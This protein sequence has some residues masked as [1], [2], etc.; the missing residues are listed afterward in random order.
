MSLTQSLR[1]IWRHP[2]NRGRRLAAVGRFVNWQTAGRI[3]KLP[4]LV[5]L[6]DK[7][8]L[9]ARHGTAAGATGN[10]YCGLH[11]FPDMPFVAHLLREGDLFLD[12][13]ANIGSYTVLAGTRGAQVIAAEPVPGT[14][15]SLRRNVGL[16]LLGDA[17]DAQQVALGESSGS[18]EMTKDFDSENHIAPGNADG[19]TRSANTVTV[20]MR[21]LDD[22][23]GDRSPRLMKLDVEGFEK[24][25]LLGAGRVLS[26]PRLLAIVIELN[27][28]GRRYGVD[29]G[30]IDA[31]LR[32][33][34]FAPHDYDVAA[35]K[36][37]PLDHF[38][39]GGNTIYARS[40]DELHP[41]LQQ[42]APV[43]IF[44]RDV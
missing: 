35:R 11:E 6:T 5:P 7:G 37:T 14:F 33:A 17:V 3:S 38:H 31:L 43:S 10:L 40:L 8:M 44:G 13:G 32:Q 4:A 28:C 29:D 23:V 25:A 16:N 30:E 34:G 26:D 15:E 2:L 1:F 41:L 19:A 21:T 9:I 36:L 20:P 27:G 22:L 39:D 18:V 12:I 42:A 24:P